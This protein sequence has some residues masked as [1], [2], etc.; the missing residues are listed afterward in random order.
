MLIRVL[1]CLDTIPATSA[2]FGEVYIA[3]GHYGQ[4]LMAVVAARAARTAGGGGGGGGGGKSGS[5]G[6]GGSGSGAGAGLG[7]KR[8]CEAEDWLSAADTAYSRGVIKLFPYE[9]K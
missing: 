4:Q 5:G 7:L 2:T 9:G 3:S 8:Q 6:A 1:L